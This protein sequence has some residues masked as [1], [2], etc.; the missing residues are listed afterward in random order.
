MVCFLRV[1]ELEELLK[2][3]E[4]RAEQTL[5]EETRRH[6][7]AYIKMERDKSTHIELLHSR[8]EAH[9]HKYKILFWNI[10]LSEYQ[11]AETRYT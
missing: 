1:N 9:A 4:T 8:W 6:R 2:D 3:Q 5:Q 10:I 7:E 11:L